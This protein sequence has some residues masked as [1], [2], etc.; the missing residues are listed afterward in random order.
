MLLIY[1]EALNKNGKTQQAIS[2]LNMIRK[3]AGLSE[4]TTVTKD[5]ARDKIY[6]ERRFELGMEGVRWSDLVRT[7]RAL[8][9]MAP[10][11]MKPQMTVFPIPLIEVQI[12]NNPAIF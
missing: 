11:G 9:A 12:I 2:Y 4:Y 6:N 1:A 5:E 8:T 3:R 10:F 7:G